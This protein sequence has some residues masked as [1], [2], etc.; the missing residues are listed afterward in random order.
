MLSLVIVRLKYFQASVKEA[1]Q[2]M[3]P[4]ANFQHLEMRTETLRTWDRYVDLMVLVLSY[5]Y[6]LMQIY[7]HLRLVLSYLISL[8]LNLKPGKKMEKKKS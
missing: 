1:Q 7:T 3:T 2:K 4:A 6:Y 5:C 8:H